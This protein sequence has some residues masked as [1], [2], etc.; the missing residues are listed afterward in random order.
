MTKAI[1][2][3]QSSFTLSRGN[4]MSSLA[5]TMQFGALLN[6]TGSGGTFA[7]ASAAWSE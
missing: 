4:M 6:S 7:P 5:P 1:S 2:A 3:S